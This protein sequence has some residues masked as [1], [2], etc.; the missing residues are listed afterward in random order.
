M[1]RSEPVK[2]GTAYINEREGLIREVIEEV[3]Q[4]RIKFNEF[5]KRTG[6]LI[7]PPMRISY[8]RPFARWASRE[9]SQREL[10]WLHPNAGHAWLASGKAGE[11]NS[12]DQDHRRARMEQVIQTNVLHR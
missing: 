11:E 6:R 1:P 2:V 3:D 10:G 8:K 4:F 9:A 12:L 7:S 5:D